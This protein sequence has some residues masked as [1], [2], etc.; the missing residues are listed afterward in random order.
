MTQIQQEEIDHLEG[1]AATYRSRLRV[2]DRQIAAYGLAV[3]A[4]IVLDRSQTEQALAQAMA[5]LRRLRPSMTEE[6]SP[7]VGLS[8]FQERDAEVFFGREQLVADLVAR[9]ESHA[10]LAVLGA[11][12]S[13]KSSVVR[14]GLIPELKAAHCQAVRAGA[15]QF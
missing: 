10:F 7:Y 3:P 9:V 8:S 4:H 5:E 6:R 11:S 14:A 12:G 1:I 13:G 2:L 15:T